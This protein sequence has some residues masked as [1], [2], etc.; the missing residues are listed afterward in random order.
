MLLAAV[1]YSFIPLA[2]MLSESSDTPF[3]FGAGW[4]S[5]IAIAYTVFLAARFP[6]LFFNVAVW[7]LVGRRLFSPNILLVMF[8]Y[9]DVVLF[10]MSI[11]HLDV[12]VATMMLELTPSSTCWSCGSPIEMRWATRRSRGSGLPRSSSC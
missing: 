1:G 6:G 12:A 11:R 8:A 9:F 7:R 5:G 2:V 3:L 10:A 4:R